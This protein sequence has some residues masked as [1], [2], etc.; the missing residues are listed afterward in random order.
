MESSVGSLRS[1]NRTVHERRLKAEAKKKKGM[2]NTKNRSTPDDN[3]KEKGARNLLWT[4]QMDRILIDTLTEQLK[5]GHRGDNGWKGSAYQEVVEQ[6][7]RK[8]GLVISSDNVRNRLKVWR[9]HYMAVKDCLSH[10]GFTWDNTLKMVTASNAVWD[11]YIKTHKKAAIYRT[12]YFMNW[13]EIVPLVCN[14]QALRNQAKTDRCTDIDTIGNKSLNGRVSRTRRN[15]IIEDTVADDASDDTHKSTPSPASSSSTSRGGITPLKRKRIHKDEPNLSSSLQSIADS[16]KSIAQ[17]MMERTRRVDVNELLSELKKVPDIDTMLLFEVAEYL[18]ADFHRA[19][20]F[21]ALSTEERKIW[22]TKRF[23]LQVC[24]RDAAWEFTLPRRFMHNLV[25]LQ[26]QYYVRH[27][28][29][30][31]ASGN[32]FQSYTNKVQLQVNDNA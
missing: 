20:L 23:P 7:N 28:F 9:N 16:M 11:E 30:F 12:K 15:P 24:S 17:A 18:L 32:Y 8:L 5:L 31:G 21:F 25:S 14:D 22:L 29:W 13:D 26:S 4:T 19:S 3:G 1:R 2:E 27:M 10:S 6:M